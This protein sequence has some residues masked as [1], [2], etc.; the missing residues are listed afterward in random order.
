MIIA[1]CAPT[2]AVAATRYHDRG[3]KC[4]LWC[5]LGSQTPTPKMKRGP[6]PTHRMTDRRFWKHYLP[7]RSVKIKKLL[8]VYFCWLIKSQLI[9]WM[10]GCRR[11]GETFRC[12]MIIKWWPISWFVYQ[13]KWKG[14]PEVQKWLGRQFIPFPVGVKVQVKSCVLT[15]TEYKFFYFEFSMINNSVRSVCALCYWFCRYQPFW[16]RLATFSITL[17]F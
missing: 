7:L 17:N 4:D 10:M 11:F 13:W 16:Q 5:M 2:T 14:T 8:W 6:L 1:G 3:A 9:H 12:F 15:S